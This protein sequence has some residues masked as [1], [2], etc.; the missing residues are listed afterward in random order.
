MRKSLIWSLI[1]FFFLGGY[2]ALSFSEPETAHSVLKSFILEA[3]ENNPKLDAARHRVFSAEKGISQAGALPDPQLLVSLS[4][5]PAD[6][7]SFDQDP[8][9]GKVIGIMQMIPFPGKLALATEMAEFEAGAIRYQ[10]EEVH[11]KVIQMVKQTYFDLYAIDRALETTKKNRELMEQYIHVAETKYATGSG[12]QQDVLRAQVEVSKL[13]DDLLMWR[14]KRLSAAARLNAI[15]N[16]PVEAH[17]D[18]TL[19]DRGLPDSPVKVYAA[20]KIEQNRPLLK[21]WRE[22]IRKVEAAVKL[23]KRDVWPNF[24]LGASYRQ[25]D[26][27]ADGRQM[28]DFFSAT[29]SMNI[30]VYFK[31][32]QNANIAEKELT[33]NA[34]MSEYEDIK[35]HVLSE[36]TSIMAAIERDRKRVE[37]YEGGI[38]IQAQQSL[39]SAHAGYRVGKVDF[40]TL[41]NNWL[42]LQNYELQYFFAVSDYLKGLADYEYAVGLNDIHQISPETLSEEREN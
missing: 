10:F 14:Q 9:T 38:L 24:S 42:M 4:N 11:N 39:E 37:L 13:E 17:I 5:L 25:R 18:K 35:I 19:P 31:R 1:F 22:R 3:L 8:M 41:L 40:L 21:A 12:L 7:L 27:L 15:L 28:I 6:S 2:N 30:P 20:E 36:I 26:E 34:V 33:L 16:R 32:K 29:I 23:S